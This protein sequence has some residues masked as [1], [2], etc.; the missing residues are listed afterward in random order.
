MFGRVVY[1]LLNLVNFYIIFIQQIHYSLFFFVSVL[2]SSSLCFPRV[3][4]VQRCS[5]KILEF[6]FVEEHLSVILALKPHTIMFPPLCLTAAT[7]LKWCVKFP[8]GV[9]RNTPLSK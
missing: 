5:F 2:S 3:L 1:L 7:M 6:L 8:L 4:V 9:T